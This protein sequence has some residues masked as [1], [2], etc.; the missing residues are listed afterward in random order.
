ME[1]K[2]EGAPARLGGDIDGLLLYTK[3]VPPPPLLETWRERRFLARLLQFLAAATCFAALMVSSFEVN[4]NSAVI[5]SSGIVFMTTVCIASM[6]QSFS[7][8]F[9]YS[10]P[11]LL[12]VP[13]SR[14]KRFSRVEVV[15]DVLFLGFW[16][17]ASSVVAWFGECPRDTAHP[18]QKSSG[19]LSWNLCMAFG[20]VCCG[21]FLATF[22]LGIRDLRQ[23]GW[24]YRIGENSVGNGFARGH[25]ASPKRSGGKRS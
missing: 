8:M 2:A 6:M 9:L 1:P 16:V 5:A 22:V 24:G 20:Y 13:P 15:I 17:G 21:L 18:P 14:H 11:V 25:W 19:C 12:G 23:Y 7:C 4:Y 3:P 10:A